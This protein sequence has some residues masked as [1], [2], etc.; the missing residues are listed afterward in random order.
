MSA[1]KGACQYARQAD[2]NSYKKHNDNLQVIHCPTCLHCN[3]RMLHMHKTHTVY[4]KLMFM[5]K[6]FLHGL[7]FFFFF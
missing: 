2:F 3:I 1:G 6:K 4:K 5:L 7:S